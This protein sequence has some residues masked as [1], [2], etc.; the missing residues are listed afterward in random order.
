MRIK[1]KS[2]L[3]ICFLTLVAPFNL[4]SP[5]GTGEFQFQS[6]AVNA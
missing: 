5:L 1:P 4:Y 2:L 6:L 3:V